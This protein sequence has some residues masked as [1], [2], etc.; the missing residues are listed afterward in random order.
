[1]LLTLPT[2]ADYC[3]NTDRMVPDPHY[4][5]VCRLNSGLGVT[6]PCEV[7]KIEPTECCTEEGALENSDKCNG[8]DSFNEMIIIVLSNALVLQL[9]G[10][11]VIQM[12]CLFT[13]CSP[14]LFPLVPFSLIPSVH[15]FTLSS[16]IST[17]PPPPPP[18][19]HL[20][21]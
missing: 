21:L 2:V 17:A 6:C 14:F 20:E 3:P 9:A 5:S 4:K 16:I 15:Y 12:Y 7:D 1:M 10:M 19:H 8:E 18:P 13:I 11:V